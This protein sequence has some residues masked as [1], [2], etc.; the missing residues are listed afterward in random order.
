MNRA[1]ATVA[2]AAWLVAAPGVVAGAVP[3]WLTGWE[4]G[5]VPAWWTGPRLAGAAVVAMG[6]AVV[7][8][9]FGE[10][11]VHG[12]GTPVPAAPTEHL[13]VHGAY[14]WVRNPMYLAVVA[15]VAGQA[16]LLGRPVL[17]GYAAVLAAVTAAF[18]HGYE[19]PTL[20]RTFGGEYDAYRQAVPAW[21]PRLR[22]RSAL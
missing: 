18:V 20:R 2:S 6:S 10:F 21:V 17:A 4:S 22:P 1:A 8:A 3:W 5:D 11:V 7:V 13:V 14:R 15:V 19:E 9:A 16:V 12:R